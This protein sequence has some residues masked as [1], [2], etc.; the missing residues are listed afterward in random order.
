[1][2]RARRCLQVP[3]EAPTSHMAHR[4]ADSLQAVDEDCLASDQ[5]ARV[6]GRVAAVCCLQRM[7]VLAASHSLLDGQAEA[8]G[9]LLHAVNIDLSDRAR[10]LS[11]MMCA[12]EL[13]RALWAALFSEAIAEEGRGTR[14]FYRPGGKLHRRKL[15]MWQALCV[16]VAFVPDAD[17]AA[18][19]QLMV[20]LCQVGSWHRCHL[21]I[22]TLNSMCDSG[23]QPCIRD[24]IFGDCP[25]APHPAATRPHL[26]HPLAGRGR[27]L[28][29]VRAPSCCSCLCCKE[30]A[31][32]PA[33]SP[34]IA[35]RT[36]G[37]ASFI[38]VL[39]QAI[40]HGDA[41]LRQRLLQPALTAMLP[42]TLTHHHAVRQYTNHCE[43]VANNVKFENPPAPQCRTFSQLAL[44]VLLESF[45]EECGVG[46][47]LHIAAVS[48]FLNA[49][50]DIM[51]LKRAMG[52]GIR[53]FRPTASSD[54]YAIFHSVRSCGETLPEMPGA[55][56]S[57]G[58]DPGEAAR[59][60][61]HM[62]GAQEE[63]VDL[64]GAPVPLLDRVIHFLNVERTR[65][66][67][68]MLSRK[69]ALDTPPPSPGF[70]FCDSGQESGRCICLN[71]VITL[72]APSRLQP[73]FSNENSRLRP[74]LTLL[75]AIGRPPSMTLS[76]ARKVT[77]APDLH[78]RVC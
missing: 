14:N 51:R 24:A 49:N 65:T 2:A 4:L 19:A 5:A 44:D 47:N 57:L 38:L 54:P 22:A 27:L 77:G 67:A 25:V 12:G 36:D 73:A 52:P 59:Q 62:A 29:E 76:A 21:E 15:R 55:F 30:H 17:T 39:V 9:A 18:A 60:G 32:R 11:A 40:M 78:A 1:M 74:P 48:A 6:A 42:W 3:D 8:A 26:V 34:F 37:L 69:A 61:V 72:Q 70:C 23:G 58:G 7:S 66:R 75:A 13:G 50:A 46:D 64:E 41:Q 53:I 10:L 33:D 63:K 56:W 20:A 45:P 16:L 71:Q 43:S 35:T 31:P 28:K 68:E